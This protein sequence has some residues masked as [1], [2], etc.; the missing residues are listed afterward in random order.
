MKTFFQN[1]VRFFVLSM[2]MMALA[3]GANAQITYSASGLSLEGAPKHSYLGLTVNKW[4]GMYWTCKTSNF[5][6]LDI[7]PTNPRIAG[8]GDEI[9]FYNSA[10]HTFN[11]IQVANV[12]NYSDAR[13]KENVKTLTTGFEK[14]LNLRPVSY[15]WKQVDENVNTANIDMDSES[16]SST[17]AYGPAIEDTQYGFLAQEVEEIIPEAVKTDENGHKMINYTVIIPMLVQAVQELQSTVALQ[18]QKIEQ[19][20]T[21]SQFA[22]DT[23][24][25]RYK[26][27]GYTPN[28]ANN[29]ITISTQLDTDAKTGVLLIS[30]LTGLEEVRFNVSYN[31]PTIT[32]NIANIAHGLHI[33]TLYVN[34]KIYDSVRILKE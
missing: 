26:I 12:Y 29:T 2:C 14:V 10:T 25:A 34:G 24:V 4:L 13:A 11:S 32:G 31:N 7:S 23:N 6:Q 28:P 30:S 16:I 3:M 33:V 22:S 1:Y 19:L 17:D 15:Q 9:V 27:L 8:T 18:A 21:P 20:S 5:F